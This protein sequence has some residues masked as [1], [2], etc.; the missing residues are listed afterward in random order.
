MQPDPLCKVHAQGLC[1]FKGK[2]RTASAKTSTSRGFFLKQQQQKN[3]LDILLVIKV[4][5]NVTQSKHCF[6]GKRSLLNKEPYP[7]ERIPF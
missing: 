6:E 7:E 3:C 2:E 1:V 4:T 5:H